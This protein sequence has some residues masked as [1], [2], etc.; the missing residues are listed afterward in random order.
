MPLIICQCDTY[1]AKVCGSVIPIAHET[2]N[3]G[4]NWANVEI[5]KTICCSLIIIVAIC[6]VGFLIW[7]LIELLAKRN[8]DIRKRLWDVD[9]KERKQKAE[10]RNRTWMHEDEACKR[11]Y[12]LED[13]ACKRKYYIEDEERKRKY[14]IEDEERKHNNANKNDDE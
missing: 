9:D 5:A 6:V 8:A 4:M 2:K 12:Y 3:T 14:Y 11:K 7:R 13:E 10:E 1:V